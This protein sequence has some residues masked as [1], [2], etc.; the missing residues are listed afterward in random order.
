LDFD[1]LTEA[2]D[3]VL[4]YGNARGL[5]PADGVEREKSCICSTKVGISENEVCEVGV[6]A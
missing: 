2:V 4:L 3:S 5:E 1:V 6:C